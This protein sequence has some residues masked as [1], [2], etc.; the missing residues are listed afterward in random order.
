VKQ[1]TMIIQKLS[2]LLV[3]LVIGF[4]I[5]AQDATAILN[6]LSAKTKTYKTI[7]AEYNGQL[8]DQ[9]IG[10]VAAQNGIIKSKGQ[11]YRLDLPDYL[12]ICDG[13][14]VWTYEKG[15]NTCFIDYLE[16]LSG[17]G[18]NPNE[19]FTIWEHDFKTELMG[20]TTIGGVK[21]YH[22]NLYPK[23]PADK[24]YHTIQMYVDKSKMQVTRIVV[25]GREGDTTTYDVK[26][27][28]P[29]VTLPETEF[30]FNKSDFP[31]VTIVDQ[32]L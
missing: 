16:D 22:I 11:K 17:G 5:S 14:N 6:D 26:K 13:D 32:R 18:I 25:K 2:T 30:T 4:S 28:T 23:N 15:S 7:V 21:S 8:V 27:F 29:N 31:G 19:L 9:K 1:T 10:E 24:P 20:E 12:I 3:A